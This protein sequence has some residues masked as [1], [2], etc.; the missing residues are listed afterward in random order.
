LKAAARAVLKVSAALIL[1]AVICGVSSMT[2]GAIMSRPAE[3]E[4]LSL[5]TGD[6]SDILSMRLTE[7]RMPQISRY[8]MSNRVVLEFTNTLAAPSIESLLEGK[9]GGCVERF[10]IQMFRPM[11]DMNLSGGVRQTINKPK[12]FLVAYVERGCDVHVQVSGFYVSATYYRIGDH[13]SQPRPAPFREIRNVYFSRHN[14]TQYLLVQLNE[15]VEPEI[16]ERE[17]PLRVI[18]KFPTTRVSGKAENQVFRYMETESLFGI[19]MLGIGTMPAP[20]EELD[21]VG[22][23]HFVGVPTPM[24]RTDYSEQ[25]L[26]F[27]SNDTI[28]T[29]YPDEDVSYR[30]LRRSGHIFEMEFT[31]EEE[32]VPD[33]C[34]VYVEEAAQPQKSKLYEVDDEEGR[35]I[36]IE[37]DSE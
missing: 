7:W 36:D 33:M 2:R 15:P 30:V 22:G 24:A 31:R 11:A 1:I 12:T 3:I 27:Q 9:R 26:G 34:R 29:I 20:Y 16:I 21:D 19:E 8:G 35:K 10:E 37:I 32:T 14:Q 5:N 4:G 28:M 23:Y 6:D 13:I 17:D 18:L 25:I